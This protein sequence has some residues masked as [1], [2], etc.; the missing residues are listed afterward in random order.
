METP[1][2][3]DPQFDMYCLAAGRVSTVWAAL[4]RGIDELIWELSDTTPEKG[5]CLT[6]QMIGPGPRVRALISLLSVWH[7]H[8]EMI[9]KF[10]RFDKAVAR[11]GT[12]RNRYSHDT[13]HLSLINGLIK[14]E[15]TA[16][17]TLRFVVDR[18]DL[19]DLHSLWLEIRATRGTLI[20]LREEL[21]DA[22]PEWKNRH[23]ERYVTSKSAG[24]KDRG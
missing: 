10:N 19:R 23:R 3:Y 14:Q 17:K 21:I 18:V 8:Q 7:A 20:E 4:E 5:A 1:D 12:K 22:V 2:W 6:S 11:L 24:K 9:A 16:D 13:V 15:V